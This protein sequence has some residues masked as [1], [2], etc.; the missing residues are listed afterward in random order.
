[1]AYAL[2]NKD[3]RLLKL[4]ANKFVKTKYIAE[5]G[6]T[7]NKVTDKNSDKKIVI[8]TQTAAKIENFF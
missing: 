1:M 3:K 2:I 6:F 4:T 7:P 8:T 5:T